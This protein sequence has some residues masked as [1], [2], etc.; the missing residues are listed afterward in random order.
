MSRVLRRPMFRGGIANSD[1]T[2]ITF[3]LDTPRKK[4]AEPDE[5]NNYSF[6]QQN[7]TYDPLAYNSDVSSVS[8]ALIVTLFGLA[9]LFG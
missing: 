1:G 2:G 7:D 4:Y 3:G 5:E 6:V 9:H 8:A